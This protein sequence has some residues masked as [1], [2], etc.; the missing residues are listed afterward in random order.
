[1][2]RESPA[3]ALYSVWMQELQ[4]HKPFIMRKL[5]EFLGDP[6]LLDVRFVL[7]ER[8]ERIPLQGEKEGESVRAVLKCTGFL[9]LQNFRHALA[10]SLI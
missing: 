6:A 3:A 5:N 8:E 4:F 10:A 7:G 2:S 9:S 1:M